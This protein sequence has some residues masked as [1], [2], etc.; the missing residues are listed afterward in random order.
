M[1]TSNYQTSACRYCGHFAPEG[2]R[3][4]NCEQLGVPVRGGW[5][6]CSLAIPAFAPSWEGLDGIVLWQGETLSVPDMMPL[7]CFAG[8]RDRQNRPDTAKLSHKH[9]HRAESLIV[10]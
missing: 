8:S 5:K 4:G 7:E 6:A 10:A 2:R 9:S 3:G 1:K